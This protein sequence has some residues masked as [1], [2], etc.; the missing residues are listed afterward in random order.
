MNSEQIRSILL[1]CVDDRFETG[2]FACDQLD[3]VQSRQFAIVVNSDDSEHRG[4]H[5]LAIVK[6]NGCN[7]EF[8]DSFSMPI[9]FYS[10]YIKKF[11]S[12]FSKT[13]QCSKPQLQSAFSTTCGHFCLYY[14]INRCSGRSLESIMRDFSFK[15][16]KSN[17]DAVQTFIQTNFQRPTS[18]ETS[19]LAQVQ[20]E[21]NA[22]YSCILQC[23]RTR[24]YLYL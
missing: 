10:P 7:I 17:D 14:I 11:L 13:I 15:D 18:Q 23:C 19:N 24:K 21:V 12:K 9:S 16:L 2:V 3:S 5:W 6:E 20:R 1:E 22:L 4:T 8:F